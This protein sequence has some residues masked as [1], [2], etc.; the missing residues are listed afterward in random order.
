MKAPVWVVKLRGSGSIAVDLYLAAR[1]A[2][3]WWSVLRRDAFRFS[4]REEAKRAASCPGSRVVRLVP[5]K[6]GGR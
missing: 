2:D 3:G 5:R 1:V 4:S 6:R